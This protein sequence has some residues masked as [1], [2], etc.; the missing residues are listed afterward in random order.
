MWK[1]TQLGNKGYKLFMAKPQLDMWLRPNA[2]YGSSTEVNALQYKNQILISVFQTQ[3]KYSL[4]T[5]LQANLIQNHHKSDW[6]NRMSLQ[7]QPRFSGCL[8]PHNIVSRII[9]FAFNKPLVICNST[10]NLYIA[11]FTSY[12]N[13]L[14]P[15]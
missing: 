8:N 10:S 2:W 11:S 12:Y 15:W 3:C 1:I 5:L 4:R 13:S 6:T 14:L 9:S 7:G